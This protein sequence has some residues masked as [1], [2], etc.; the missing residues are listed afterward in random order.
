MLVGSTDEARLPPGIEDRLA[1]FAELVATAIANAQSRAD[2]EASRARLVTEADAA[3][4][5]VVRDLHD[6][7]QQRLV[8]TVITLELAQRALRRDDHD[9]EPLIAE[10]LE[11]SQQAN[12]ELRELAHG[13]LPADLVRGGLQGGVDAFVERL[14]LAVE[15]DLPPERFPAEIEASAYF[16]VAEALT[17]I[18]KHA[19]AESAAVSA[20]VQDGRLQLEVRDDGIGGADPGGRGLV[21]LNDR[22]TALRG[23]LSVHSPAGGGT[24]L[25]ATLPVSQI[26]A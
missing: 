2:L 11:H 17:N 19:R 5:R 18:V 14:G 16:I 7:A 21:G 9:V 6:G 13:I 25:T 8:H 3:R 4:R 1:A 24:V 12:A 20:S 15:V 23:R 22:V 10:A 26:T